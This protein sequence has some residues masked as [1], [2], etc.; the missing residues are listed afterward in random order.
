MREFLQ[1]MA[2]DQLIDLAEGYAK[3]I[4]AMD[5][6]WFQ[7]TEKSFGMDQAMEQDALA[8]RGFAPAEACRL[9]KMLGLPGHPGLGGLEQVLRLR[10]SS[11][12]NDNVTLNWEDD[13]AALV[14]K[15]G[16]CR[17]QRA[18]HRKGMPLHPCKPVCL[19]EYQGIASA[20]DD[21]ITCQCLSCFPDVVDESCCCAWRFTLS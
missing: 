20:V 2:K 8:W 13:G 14:Y 7:A 15:V 16:D 21:R 11:H 19:I 6:V 17:V 9:K 18:R 1:D 10:Y 5:G 3:N 4:V 12:A